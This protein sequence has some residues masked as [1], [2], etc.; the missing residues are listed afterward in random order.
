MRWRK[1]SEKNWVVSSLPNRIS[2]SVPSISHLDTKSNH[3]RSLSLDQAN[4]NRLAQAA[5]AQSRGPTRAGSLPA[6]M[7]RC[8]G[9]GRDRSGDNSRYRHCPSMQVPRPRQLFSELSAARSPTPSNLSLATKRAWRCGNYPADHFSWFP[10]YHHPAQ[11]DSLATSFSKVCAA[12]FSPSTVVRYG[13]I[14]A[15]RSS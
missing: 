11:Q 12:N 5:P 3:C 14:I 4:A 1:D 13:K 7:G 15:P 10:L 6:E 8:S 9:N 2:D